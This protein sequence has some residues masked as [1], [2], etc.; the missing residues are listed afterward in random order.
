L[1][2]GWGRALSSPF[3]AMRKR[4]AE[5]ISGRGYGFG[6]PRLGP[7][8]EWIQY[9]QKSAIALFRADANAVCISSPLSQ[10]RLTPSAAARI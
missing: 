2:H 6:S 9:G 4:R 10:L 7:P 1:H 5:S 3:R 8:R